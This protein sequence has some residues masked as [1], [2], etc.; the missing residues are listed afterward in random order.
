[1]NRRAAASEPSPTARPLSFPLLALLSSLAAGSCGARTELDRTGTLGPDAGT[2]DSRSPDAAPDVPVRVD[3]EEP[4]VPSIFDVSPIPE[5]SPTDV[6][7]VRA[8]DATPDAGARGLFAT[9]VDDSAKPLPIGSVD[10]HYT[11][12]SSDPGMPGPNALAVKPASG[13]I[14]DQ[15]TSRWISGTLDAEG[16]DTDYTY[17]MTFDLVAADPATVPITGRWTC[18]DSCVMSLNGVT[19]ASIGP[20]NE[21]A[22]IVDFA[23]PAGGPLVAG[24]NLL[25]IV[26]DNSGGGPTGLQIVEI[27]RSP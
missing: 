13:W 17:S 8:T 6:D 3:V 10:P 19:V 21:W 22:S 4:D 9:G 12:A 15:P 20:P 25:T 18:D 23:I 1:M 2:V 7:D 11:L 27:T 26:V 5:A 16:I 24:P 14:A